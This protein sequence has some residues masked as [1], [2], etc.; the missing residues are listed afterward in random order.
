MATPRKT[1]TRKP[2]AKAPAR[3]VPADHL[4][5]GGDPAAELPNFWEMPGHE[6]FKPLD[7]IDVDTA[8]E[9]LE[10]VDSLETHDEDGNPISEIRLSREL[11]KIVISEETI[12]DMETFRKDF[13]NAANMRA[14]GEVASAFIGVLGKGVN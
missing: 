7:E 13:Y 4:P 9:I 12:S 6:Y 14:A 11:L 3:K 10:K 5:K 2:A 1:T 8:L